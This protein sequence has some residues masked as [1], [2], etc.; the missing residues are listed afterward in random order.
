MV[1]FIFS[2]NSVGLSHNVPAVW[3]PLARQSE[4][5]GGPNKEMRSISKADKLCRRNGV[6][7]FGPKICA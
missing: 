3:K 7:M 6:G 5:F 1:F 4:K 2:R